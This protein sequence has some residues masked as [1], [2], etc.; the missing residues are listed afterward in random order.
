VFQKAAKALFI[1][2]FVLG[3]IA[4]FL[5]GMAV[6]YGADSARPTEKAPSRAE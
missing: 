1:I 3:A 5:V 6:G 2:G 4:G